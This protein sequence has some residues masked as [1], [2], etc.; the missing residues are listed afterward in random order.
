MSARF[1]VVRGDSGWWARFRAGNG[2]VIWVTETYTRRRAAVAALHQIALTPPN[3]PHKVV[4]FGSFEV[5]DV[6]EREQA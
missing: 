1:E 4:G 5:R 3:L 6:D 2:R